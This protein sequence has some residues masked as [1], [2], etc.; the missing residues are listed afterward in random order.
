MSIGDVADGCQQAIEMLKESTEWASVAHG[1]LG[2]AK[3]TLSEVL[4]EESAYF[5]HVV[6][7]YGLIV[8]SLE[9]SVNS[10]LA[11]IEQLD[12]YVAFILGPAATSSNTTGGSGRSPAGP[13]PGTGPD[14]EVTRPSLEPDSR[15]LPGGTVSRAKEAR[16][17][18]E[19]IRRENAAAVVLTQWGYDVTQN[20]SP[21]A[22]G[23]QPDYLIEGRYWDC[24]SPR[25]AN[26]GQIRKRMS[27]KVRKE[28]ADRI[29]LH[30]DPEDGGPVADMDAIRQA[31]DGR[32]ISGLREI[33]IV[34]NQ[35]VIDFYPW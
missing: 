26:G 27:E 2:A 35:Q 5:D 17:E 20:P 31:L 3:A 13:V 21:R 18:D 33:K 1:R 19:G 28:Q 14:A 32:P 12:G 29:I 7:P 23:R 4:S 10:L 9:Q 30:L 11:A 25:T 22:N 34:H 6:A 24:L 16:T 15:R 8:E